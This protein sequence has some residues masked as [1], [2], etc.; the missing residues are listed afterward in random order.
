MAV[1][2]MFDPADWPA[3]RQHALIDGHVARFYRPS[4]LPASIAPAAKIPELQR[5]AR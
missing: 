1:Q 3:E 4:C 2:V 5:R